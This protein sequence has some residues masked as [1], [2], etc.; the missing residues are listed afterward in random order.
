M[1]LYRSPEWD[2]EHGRRHK[3]PARLMRQL[4]AVLIHWFPHRRFVFAGDGGYGTHALAR[5]A[6]RHRRRL[7][8]VSRFY[9]DAHLYEPP[10]EVVG[11]RPVGPARRGRSSRRLRSRSP[12]RPARR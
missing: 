10:P 4:L 7:T 8:L 11:K 3:T 6:H 5:F 2:R 12:R 1:A 9:P